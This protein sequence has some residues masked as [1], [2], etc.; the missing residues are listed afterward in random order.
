LFGLRANVGLMATAPVLAFVP[1]SLKPAD[2]LMPV[3]TGSE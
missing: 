2:R 1:E 3:A